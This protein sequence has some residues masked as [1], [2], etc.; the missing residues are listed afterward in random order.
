M[1]HPFWLLSVLTAALLCSSCSI[2]VVDSQE[3][4]LPEDTLYNLRLNS[5]S[6]PEGQFMTDC[7]QCIQG[8]MSKLS[9]LISSYEASYRD[10][11]CAAPLAL[12]RYR[13]NLLFESCAQKA[14]QQGDKSAFAAIITRPGRAA[15]IAQRFY[16]EGNLTDGAFWL[17][18][19]VNLLGEKDGLTTA[20]RIFVQ[21]RSTLSTG[22]RLLEQAARLGSREAAQILLAL[23]MPSS[24][25]YQQLQP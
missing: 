19:V 3:R 21:S 1:Q 9:R 5:A 20:G 4:T 10:T 15:R 8:D 17:Q 16:S 14:L 2:E 7:L 12:Q 18:R 13:P 23:T 25:Y 6:T 22:A 11:T 24:S